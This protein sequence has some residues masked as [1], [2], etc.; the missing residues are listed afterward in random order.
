MTLPNLS[1]ATRR[2][3]S[4][5]GTNANCVEIAELAEAVAVRD[6][7]DVTGPA[8]AFGPAAWTSFVTGVRRDGFRPARPR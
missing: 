8:L 3:S 2:K 5:S 1:G 4:R 7:K 6:S